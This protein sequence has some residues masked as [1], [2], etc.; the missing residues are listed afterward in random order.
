MLD[1]HEYNTSGNGYQGN[2]NGYDQLDGD[3]ALFYKVAKGFV[4][5]V[6]LEDR[7]DFL[8]DL[9]LE[10]AKVKAKYEVISKPLTEGG[11]IR[12]AYYRVAHYWR[13]QFRL[14]NGVYC[15]N[16]SKAQRQRCREKD[17]YRECPKATKIESLAKLIEDG[18][19]DRTELYEMIADDNAVDIVARLDARNTLNGYPHRFVQIAYK[20]YAG[21]PLTNEERAYLYRQRR[22]AQKSLVLA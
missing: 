9:L 7:Q 12:V 19:G 4:R 2:G 17:L 22:K 14:T 11:L 5:R 21:Y 1:Y 20:K 15:H 16:C 18:N 10:M 3:W 6:K 13:E 8:H